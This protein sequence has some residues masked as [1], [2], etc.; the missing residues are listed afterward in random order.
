MSR[1]QDVIVFICHIM[2]ILL[3]TLFGT[4]D[5]WILAL[6]AFWI[7]ANVPRSIIKE[8]RICQQ[9]AATS[10]SRRVNKL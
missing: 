3:A 10:N 1:K 8:E 9:Y 4:K 5:C 6:F 7:I 2:H